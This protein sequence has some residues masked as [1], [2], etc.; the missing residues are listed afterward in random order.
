MINI[1][2]KNI[3]KESYQKLFQDK[4]YSQ[5]WKEL[6]RIVKDEGLDKKIPVRGTIEIGIVLSLL[7]ISFYS[8]FHWNFLITSFL[9]ILTFLRST[10]VAHDLIH[11]QYYNNKNLNKYLSYIF[12]NT[13]IASG[14]DW[15]ERDH[16]IEHHTWTNSANRDEDI[17]AFTFFIRE[18][19]GSP[20][21]HKNK[22]WIFWIVLPFMWASFHYQ[23][24][25][26][27]FSKEE[28]RTPKKRYIMRNFPTMLIHYIIPIT[29]LI[30][31]PFIEAISAILIIYLGYGFLASLGFITNHIGM[32]V[33]ENGRE[34]GMPWMEIQTRTSRNLNGGV[35]VHWLYGG[36]NA[37][38]EHH[39]FPK[40]P[41]MKLLKV[42]ELTK[43]YCKE[44]GLFYYSVS[45]FKAYKEIN[46]EL[47]ERGKFN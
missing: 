10:F 45:P 35:F 43:N 27:L 3:N 34:K 7:V 9:F 14:V 44:K 30:N 37:Q 20:W 19:K 31:Y 40:V 41:R 33:L 23:S 4:N 46:D 18:K 26:F 32:E 11:Q 8:I 36:L 39:L 29:I 12:G 25:K 24:W 13:I 47:H 6:Q 28:H 38:I 2:Y 1:D 21:L 42:A 5:L 17:K 15:W 22:H 16:N